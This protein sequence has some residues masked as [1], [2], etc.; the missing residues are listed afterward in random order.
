MILIEGVN[1][2]LSPNLVLKVFSIRDGRVLSTRP[3]GWLRPH[4][5]G[6]VYGESTEKQRREERF[7]ESP[8][9]RVHGKAASAPYFGESQSSA[10]GGSPSEGSRGFSSSYRSSGSGTPYAIQTPES[11]KR[12][13]VNDDPSRGNSRVKIE[14]LEGRYDEG[15]MLSEPQSSGIRRG[16]E[17][18]QR[19]PGRREVEKEEEESMPLGR[20][21]EKGEKMEQEELRT[22]VFTKE[23]EDLS[24]G[25]SSDVL[26]CTRTGDTHD[27]SGDIE[28]EIDTPSPVTPTSVELDNIPAST[29]VD[30]GFSGVDSPGE[31]DF[32]TVV[33]RTAEVMVRNIPIE[34]G[35]R[36]TNTTQMMTY[37]GQSSDGAQQT[38]IVISPSDT[39]Q[40]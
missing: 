37:D 5:G 24:D 3:D 39:I 22:P 21:E 38:A 28:P 29:N 40:K 34:G 17:K 30:L 9:R 33:T 10:K 4:T 23:E 6:T 32:D 31:M 26:G 1:G 27:T 2:I 13:L 25:V 15:P 20:K 12:M 7:R 16:V 14:L 35:G 19:S 8:E 36:P 18:M 11:S